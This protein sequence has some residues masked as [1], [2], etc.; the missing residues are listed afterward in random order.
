MTRFIAVLGLALSLVQIGRASNVPIIIESNRTHTAAGAFGCTVSGASVATPSVITCAAPHN[1]IT[2]DQV[3]ITGIGGT[4]TDN[5]LAYV[6]VLSSTTFAIYSDAA[7]T[8]G[9]TGTGSYTS[10]GLV[11]IASDISG[12]VFGSDWTATIVIN[13]NTLGTGG[14]IKALVCLQDSTTGFALTSDII[15]YVCV[16]PSTPVTTNAPL[17]YSW[18]AYQFPSLRMGVL[19]AR[20]RVDVQSQDPTESVNVTAYIK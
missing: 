7:Q 18:R 2:G 3:Q 15:T 12:W 5:T 8:M 16:N 9:I 14:A 4:T 20:I 19:N 17:T 11:S 1:L 10:G 6:T 13:S